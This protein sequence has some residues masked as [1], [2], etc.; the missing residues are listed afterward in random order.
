MKT[1]DNILER[2]ELTSQV[3]TQLKILNLAVKL[4][5]EVSFLILVFPIKRMCTFI[6]NKVFAR[7]TDSFSIDD[8][9]DIVILINSIFWLGFFYLL[10]EAPDKFIQ[11]T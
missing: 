7:R 9:I 11:E 4:N 1:K 6:H 5:V 10:S 3:V 2:A 8:M